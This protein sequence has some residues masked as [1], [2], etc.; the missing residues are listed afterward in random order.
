MIGAGLMTLR[1]KR[2]VKAGHL[3][4]VFNLYSSSH[5]RTPIWLLVL[6]D[7]IGSATTIRNRPIPA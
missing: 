4:P 6:L 7:H 1:S 3:L 2:E 5:K